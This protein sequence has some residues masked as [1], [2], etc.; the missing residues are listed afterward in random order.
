MALASWKYTRGARGPIG[1]IIASVISPEAKNPSKNN[2]NQKALPVITALYTKLGDLE[3]RPSDISQVIVKQKR[4]GALDSLISITARVPRG[5]PLEWTAWDLS[6]AAQGTPYRLSD[7][8]SDEKKQ[9]MTFTFQSDR[10][11]DPRVELIVFPSDKF[12][13]FTAKMAIIG[14]IEADTSYQTIVAFLSIPEQ[15]SV[16][17]VP[18][19]KQ[20]ALVAQLAD[21][22]HKEVIIR[23][24]LEPAGKIPDDFFGPIIMVHYTKEAIHSIIAQAMTKVPNFS[25]FNNLW[26]SRALEDSRIMG[27]VCNE[28]KKAHGY[29]IETRATKN[30]VVSSVCEN[31]GLPDKEIDAVV[32]EKSNRADIEK[33]LRNYAATAQANGTIIV[34][35]P[36][37]APFVAALKASV[38]MLKRNG[39]RLVPASEIVINKEKLN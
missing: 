14:V 38:P 33:Q 25:G 20:S 31:I 1:K 19:K 8:L 27:I 10:K 6:L 23:L 18:V 13:S 12:F 3:T 36:I 4:A 22:Y 34:E 17:L 5:R 9:V 39:I 28:I 15:A 21:Q 29:F 7:C 26:G 30:S 16:S 11:K 35:A 32:G 24:P 2:T 37:N